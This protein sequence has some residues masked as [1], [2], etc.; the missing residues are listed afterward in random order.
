[1]FLF[2]VLSFFKKGDTIQGGH[3]LRKYGTYLDTALYN[4][5]YVIY[6]YLYVPFQHVSFVSLCPEGPISKV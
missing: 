5:L 2:Y 6:Y 1:M 4:L 3:Y